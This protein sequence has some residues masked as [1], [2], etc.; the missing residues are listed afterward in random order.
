MR[1]ILNLCLLT[2]FIYSF[3]FLSPVQ[4][5]FTYLATHPEANQHYRPGEYGRHISVLRAYEG[6]IYMGYGQND[7]EV[8]W[9]NC[10]ADDLYG[11]RRFP[12][13]P[14]GIYCDIKLRYFDPATETLSDP[15]AELRAQQ[16][17]TLEVMGGNLYFLAEDPDEYEYPYVK[18]TSADNCFK[19]TL[20]GSRPEHLLSA[21]V[22]DGNLYI[23]GSDYYDGVIWRSTDNGATWQ[24]LN[25]RQADITNSVTDYIGCCSRYNGVGSYQGKLHAQAYDY[26]SGQGFHST[27]Y[28]GTTWNAGPNLYSGRRRSTFAG[29]MVFIGFYQFFTYD[30]EVKEQAYPTF[31]RDYAIS[32]GYL[33]LLQYN[34]EVYRTT[35]LQ[36]WSFVDSMPNNSS[37]CSIE[38][39]NG[40]VYVGTKESQLYKSTV[41]VDRINLFPILQLILSEDDAP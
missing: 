8:V 40:V 4:A 2:P 18:C 5:E 23:A 14:Y 19:A 21:T 16:A 41:L 11:P 38:I 27:V 1:R 34:G 9:Q 31:V 24:I 25:K 39:L 13:Y 12:D 6:K 3:V 20:T 7:R 30:G 37:G 33:Y 32:D 15:V 26:H 36:E 29:K 17:D 28:D 10:P 22:L 35:N